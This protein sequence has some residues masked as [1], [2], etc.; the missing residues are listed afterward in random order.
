MSSEATLFYV[1]PADDPSLRVI[2]TEFNKIPNDD[3]TCEV[4][5]ELPDGWSINDDESKMADVWNDWGTAFK[6]IASE[7]KDEAIPSHIFAAPV[8]CEYPG[9]MRSLKIVSR[10]WLEE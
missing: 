7:R 8:D 6:F 2:R 9:G 3:V 1:S 10:K 4:V 5:V